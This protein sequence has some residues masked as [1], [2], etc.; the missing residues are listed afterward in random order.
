MSKNNGQCH[1]CKAAHEDVPGARCTYHESSTSASR[2]KR[3]EDD[4]RRG[5]I[6][7]VLVHA[8]AYVAV[9]VP[10]FDREGRREA[11]W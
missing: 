2:S 11:V 4:G 9:R 8:F 10:T 6:G 7:P 5:P 3:Y 1:A